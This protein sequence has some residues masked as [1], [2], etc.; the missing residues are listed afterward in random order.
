MEVTVRIAVFY[1]EDCGS[2]LLRNLGVI[3]KITFCHVTNY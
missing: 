3:K 1:F 2:K